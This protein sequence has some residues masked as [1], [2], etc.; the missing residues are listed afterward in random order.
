MFL[1]GNLEEEMYMIQLEGFVSK[2]SPN[3]MCRLL[4]SI[5]ELKQTSQTW[6]IR[7]DE[8]IKSYEFVKNK[9]EPYV[10]RKVMGTKL[11]PNLRAPIIGSY[12]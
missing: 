11:S 4:R 12:R 1:N 8:A 5:Y 10:Y 6:N 2:E 9:D 3:K 7:F